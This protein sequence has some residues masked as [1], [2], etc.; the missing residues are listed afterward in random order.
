MIELFEKQITFVENCLKRQNI[1]HGSVR[2]GKTWITVF[3]WI[4]YILIAPKGD[5]LMIGRT[6]RSI[7]R[8]LI[9]IMY[10]LLGDAVKYRPGWG[11]MI[12]YDRKIFV[13]GASD[14]RSENK[15]RG[16][17]IAGAYV[18]EITLIHEDMYKM[19]LSRMSIKGAKLFGSTNPDS[20]Y[21]FIKTDFLDRLD[22]DIFHMPFEIDDNTFLDPTYVQQIKLEY[23]GLY[24]KRFIL[25]QWVI[26][27]GS[28]Y[29]SFDELIHVIQVCPPAQH[30]NVSID[31]GT[32]N[33]TVF[34]KM[35]RNR[36]ASP[37]IWCE[38]EYYYD[39]KAHNRQKTDEDYVND[40][41]K[42]TKDFKVQNVIVDPSAAS[43]IAALNKRGIYNVTHADNCVIDGIRYQQTLLNNGTYK[44][45]A[46]CVNTIKEYSG[47]VW[48][49]K[50]QL[51]GEDKPIKTSDHTKDAE[52]Y[53]LYTMRYANLYNF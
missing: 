9:S 53:D 43:F 41:V 20:P 52:R 51:I 45:H 50:K 15:I 16:M 39:S 19:V 35:G 47:Y 13:E 30:Y 36:F 48:D 3:I 25:G 12:V 38:D 7:E 40:Y 44:I 31:Y 2:S 5:L 24:Y 22:L 49:T 14:K 4:R 42:F 37:Q 18:D 32:N 29:D 26:A 11:Y 10:E 28:I 23:T 33:P 21:H 17:T 1:A 6:V 8:N 34:L 46:R 27:E